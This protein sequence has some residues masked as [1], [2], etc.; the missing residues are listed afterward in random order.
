MVDMPVEYEGQTSPE[1]GN[2][3]RWPV[4]SFKNVS[5][6]EGPHNLTVYIQDSNTW[7]I[8]VLTLAGYPRKETFHMLNKPNST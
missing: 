7:K 1:L 4:C 8:I 3:V 5:S 2:K 6:G